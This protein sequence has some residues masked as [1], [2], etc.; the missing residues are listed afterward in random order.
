MQQIEALV[1]A[2]ESHRLSRRQLI[3]ALTALTVPARASSS[4]QQTPALSQAANG[5]TLNHASL[6]VSDVASAA[7]FYQKVLGLKVVSRPGNG[8]INLGLGDG[9]LGVYKLA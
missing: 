2:Y 8:G 7:E 4:S 3:A 5:R 1:D 9:F 6:A